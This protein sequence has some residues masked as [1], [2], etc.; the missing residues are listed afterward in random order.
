M[1]EYAFKAKRFG[2]PFAE[3]LISTIVVT[4]NSGAQLFDCIGSLRNQD[5]SRYEV[6]LVNNGDL[7]ERSLDDFDLYYIALDQN[8]G[9]S[10]ARNVGAQIAKGE[11]LAFLDDD[12]IAEKNWLA[13]IARSFEDTDIVALR[14]KIRPK[15][16]N[17]VFNRVAFHYDLG[18]EVMPWFLD[19]EG[20]SAVRASAFI[21]ANG[22]NEAIFGAEGLDLSS[23]LDNESGG[24]VLY[25]PSVL[26]YHNYADNLVHFIRKSYRHGRNES[27][28]HIGDETTEAYRR[29]FYERKI[30]GNNT[31]Q[32][33]WS[34]TRARVKR[35]LTRLSSGSH[36]AKN[37]FRGAMLTT[38][39][40]GFSWFIDGVG[41]LSARVRVPFR[42]H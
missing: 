42:A 2:A 33:A 1:K 31:T 4:F 18:S 34:R 22:F 32:S 26:V 10:Y 37:G 27:A 13:N 36:G 35:G 17:N 6:I 9:P 16:K 25:E 5:F 24:R 14:G 8:Y 38:A 15:R 29:Q 12:A 40:Y 39:L 3:P 23:R 41:K 11:I 19:I 30:T 21:A 7:D 20:N 28:Q